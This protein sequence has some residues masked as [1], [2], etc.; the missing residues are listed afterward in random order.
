M[1]STGTKATNL[2]YLLNDYQKWCEP[3]FGAQ[4][5]DKFRA[6][7]FGLT[8]E[9]GEAGDAVKKVLFQGHPDDTVFRGKLLKELGDV[10]FYTAVSVTHQKGMVLAFGSFVWAAHVQPPRALD[11]SSLGDLLITLMRRSACLYE[12][13]RLVDFGAAFTNDYTQL[14]SDVLFLPGA[15]GFGIEEV[16]TTN[17]AKLEARYGAGFSVAASLQRSEAAQ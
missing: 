12:T 1:E 7:L 3:R 16:I 10:L 6:G 14:L 8:T 5:G 2:T 11:V 17:K 4:P 15:C 13:S 9:L